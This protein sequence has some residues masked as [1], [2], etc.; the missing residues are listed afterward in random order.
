[1]NPE[2]ILFAVIIQ[3]SDGIAKATYVLA[4]DPDTASARVVESMP[5]GAR[6]IHIV[7]FMAA[8]IERFANNGLHH[9]LDDEQKAAFTHERALH[10]FKVMADSHHRQQIE[11]L[12]L[13]EELTKYVE[14]MR[15]QNENELHRGYPDS[16]TATDE[17]ET[18]QE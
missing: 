18:G 13:R 11:I 1:M 9:L 8:E 5:K 4:P 16:G 3:D 14:R 17:T 10:V 6:L 15:Q 2:T 7:P 12:R